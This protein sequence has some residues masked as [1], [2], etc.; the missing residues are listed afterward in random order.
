MKLHCECNSF[1]CDKMI[2]V[3]ELEF[4]TNSRLGR[5]FIAND[6][7]HGSEHRDELV[8]KKE[9]FTIYRDGIRR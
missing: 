7:P 6:C 4:V 9:S 8:E 5:V 1:D 3:E 2:D